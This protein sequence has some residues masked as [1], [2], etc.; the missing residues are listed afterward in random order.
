MLESLIL[1][2]IVYYSDKFKKI[3]S[4][5]D[6][7]VAKT[8]LDMES[9]DL[10]VVNNYL[11]I[12]DREQISFITDRRA[13]QIIQANQDKV[14]YTGN[15]GFLS[16]SDVNKNIFARL[17]YTPQGETTYHP[18]TGEQGVILSTT[19]SPTSDRVYCKVQ[20]TGGISVINKERLRKVEIDK[21]LYS[22][23][24]QP[25]RI[26]RGIRAML[27]PSGVTFTDSEIE[28]FVNK[29]KASWDKMNDIFRNFEVVKEDKIAYWYDSRNYAERTST[30][31]SSCMSNVE[32]EYFDIYVK[33]PEK[34]SLVI[35]KN[36]DGDKILGRALLWE[37]DQPKITF[38]DRIYTVSDS[39]VQLFKDY[40][41]KMGWYH[42]STQN[43][44]TIDLMSVD[45]SGTKIYISENLTT[46]LYTSRQVDYDKFPYLDTL[47]YFNTSTGQISSDYSFKRNGGSSVITLEVTDGTWAENECDECGGS[48]S[49]GCYE[50]G[51]SGTV[52]CYECRE[53]VSRGYRSTGKVSC[54]ECDGEGE[55]DCNSCSGSGKIGDND[56][57]DCNAS[58][59]ISC[60]DCD[61]DGKND[62]TNCNGDGE[63]ECGECGGDGT[64]SCGSCS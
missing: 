20:F 15:R 25:I 12:V 10:D 54:S 58:G 44:S 5:I 23:N 1:E 7:P 38:M 57:T 8:L 46:V 30:L 51:E 29:Y 61:G 62:C 33:N 13:G 9:K 63:V 31:G 16:H 48:G 3:L 49:V 50:C 40:S 26:G 22:Q 32:S 2:S 6:S 19:Q 14:T 56:C 11:D 21:L 43:S 24:R 59:K 64:I 52:D 36:D 27:K 39:Y 28:D 60:E 18:S 37:L 45:S 47:K 42:K 34:I 41:Y 53:R 17:D 55:Q 35:L 4:A